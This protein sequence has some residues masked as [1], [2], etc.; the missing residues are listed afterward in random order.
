MIEVENLS[1]SYGS[2]KALDS[3][4]FQVPSGS[5]TG[6]LGPNG[7]GKTTTLRVLTSWLL[8]DPGTEKVMVCGV[9]LLREPRLA[10]RKVGA[11]L[12]QL[13]LPGELRVCE[14][15][16]SR[17]RLKGISGSQIPAEIQRVL[18]DVDAVDA[19]RRG[20]GT[21]S[22]GYRQ[23]IGLA[24]ALLGDPPV[25]LLDEPTRGLD[26]RQ[27][28]L[29]RELVDRLRHQ[30]TII[31]SSHVL[32]EVEQICDRVCMISAGKICLDEDRE[33]W[34]RRLEISGT[35]RVEVVD[36]SDD[37]AVGLAT[38]DGVS[39]VLT[40][41]PGWILH[42]DR[43]LRRSIG[44]LARQKEWVLSELSTDPATLESLFLQLTHPGAES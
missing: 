41:G 6:F 44:E 26:P 7:A 23:R 16:H 11:L 15:L 29:F 25:L 17:A 42:G 39:E 13:P 12:E 31:L 28:A 10:C 34:T 38:L 32:G 4:S 19:S 33:A 9:D 35:T 22:Q 40:D 36:G 37:V 14:F 43:D 5:V 18:E 1:R 2:R 20:I 8:P 3:I 21:L 27:V 24:D 30:H